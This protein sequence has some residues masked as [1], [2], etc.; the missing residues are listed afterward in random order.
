MRRTRTC[1]RHG[2]SFARRSAGR[3]PRV[4][5]PFA[6]GG[7]HPA[8]GVATGLRDARA[9]LQPDCGVAEPL[10]AGVSTAVWREGQAPPRPSPQAGR[11]RTESVPPPAGGQ[12]GGNST[13]SCFASEQRRGAAPAG[14]RRGAVAAGAGGGG[15]GRVGAGVGAGAPASRSTRPDPDG[16]IPVGYLLGAHHPVPEPDLRGGD[17]AHAARS[18]AGEEREEAGGVAAWCPIRAAKRVEFE[19]VGQK[20]EAVRV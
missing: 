3:A 18:L 8:G 19:I 5:D 7:K 1:R 4:L 20:G 10:R 6:G 2:R 11:E 13:P 14:S 12:Q 15:L 17:P 9:G 16:A